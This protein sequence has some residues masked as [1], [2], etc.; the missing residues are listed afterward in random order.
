MLPEIGKAV[1]VGDIMLDEYVICDE[2]GVRHV[3]GVFAHVAE[4]RH[5]V[6]YYLGG[7]AH[8][9]ACLTQWARRVTLVG[10]VG[11][12]E[13]GAMV[14]SLCDN[15]RIPLI[16]MPSKSGVTTRKVRVS[17]ESELLIRLDFDASDE[18]PEVMI[19]SL[20][21]IMNDS[22]LVVV[23]D[24]GKGVVGK[25][26]VEALRRLSGP[27]VVVAPKPCNYDALAPTIEGRTV[28]M[29]EAE[30][31]E[32]FALPTPRS[33]RIPTNDGATLSVVT[34]GRSGCLYA[35]RH[36]VFRQRAP[37]VALKD[38]CGAGDAFVAGLGVAR[39]AGYDAHEAVKFATACGAA[40]VCF[41]GTTAPDS[42]IVLGLLD[43]VPDYEEVTDYDDLSRSEA[44]R[45]REKA[46]V[47]A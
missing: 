26:V 38:A 4:C 5:D 7:A 45:E 2:A 22:D 40:Q 31:L 1:V 19:P 20:V 27:T 21:S 3:D 11:K 44:E 42:D 17:N 47:Q 12:D 8:T 35:T 18:I 36:G 24:Y 28:S 41:S 37:E 9:A 34:Q 14:E 43:R 16:M 13:A 33:V 46:R 32:V 15:Y 10:C 30:S 29:N 25:A 39:A 6:R 23:Q